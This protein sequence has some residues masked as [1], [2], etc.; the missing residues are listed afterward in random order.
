ME[1][2]SYTQQPSS[3]AVG[4]ETGLPQAHPPCSHHTP[5]K[6]PPPP[7]TPQGYPHG[8]KKHPSKMSS[9]KTPQHQLGLFSQGLSAPFVSQYRPQGHNGSP[10]N[11]PCSPSGFNAV[12]IPVTEV[13][14]VQWRDGHRLTPRGGK[15]LLLNTVPTRHNKKTLQITW[16]LYIYETE[17]KCA[18]HNNRKYWLYWPP[19]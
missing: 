3:V 16:F 8:M 5:A 17:K 15:R 18:P 7:I 9:Q 1:I 11:P 4:Y 12:G 14:N 19:K 10:P 13:P 2:S 6:K